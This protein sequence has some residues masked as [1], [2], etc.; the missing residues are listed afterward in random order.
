MTRVDELQLE[1][2][3]IQDS[4]VPHPFDMISL[5]QLLESNVSGVYIG[6]CEGG[7]AELTQN[8]NRRNFNPAF[9]IKCTVCSLEK[10]CTIIETC[11]MCY[12]TMKVDNLHLEPREKYYGTPYSYY[13]AKLHSCET[14]NFRS[15]TEEFDQ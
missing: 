8:P 5:P 2:K 14:C 3:S 15:V 7:Q 10:K 9:I 13:M 1:I 12:G 6:T 11:P 4:C